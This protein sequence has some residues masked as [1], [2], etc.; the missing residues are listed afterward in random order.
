MD[1]LFITEEQSKRLLDLIQTD[2]IKFEFDRKKNQ[3]LFL[4]NHLTLLTFRMPITVISP[5]AY[6]DYPEDRANY[7]M[8]I[9]RSGIA[10]VGYFEDGQNMD[11]K[12]FRAYM[13]RK[14][15][16]KSQ[17]KYLKTKGKSRA[18][19]RVRLAASLEFFEDINKRL[20]VY[21][22]N[23]HI[24]RIA[25]SC[26]VTLIPYFYGSKI[27]TPF[28]K[29]D[30]RIYKI[31]K[32]IQEPTYGS[33]LDTNRFLLAGE[34]KSGAGGEGLLNHFLIALRTKKSPLPDSENW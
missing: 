24:D 31:P 23:H 11:H 3:L 4:E 26:P 13:V 6:Y 18:G 27:P 29:G 28:E 2:K 12:V 20:T 34:L 5:E 32:H 33:L 19:S 1:N 21:F 16:G 10:T 17:I 14:K 9:I 22:D 7:V 8:V 25:L 30:G 15:Q